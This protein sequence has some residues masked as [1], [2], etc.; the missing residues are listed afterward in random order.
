MIQ[1]TKK[2]NELQHN[3]REKLPFKLRWILDINTSFV[4][5]DKKLK[6]SVTNIS[7]T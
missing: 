6:H 3:K 2:S 1:E 7:K 5:K 4:S